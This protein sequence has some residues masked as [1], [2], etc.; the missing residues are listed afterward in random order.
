MG[1]QSYGADAT[2]STN[3]ARTVLPRANWSVTRLSFSGCK[4]NPDEQ[5]HH[6]S[7][8]VSASP[9]GEEREGEEREKRRA[10]SRIHNTEDE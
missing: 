1:T 3:V 7:L 2:Q 10:V 4:L 8:Y 5:E 9:R 6:S